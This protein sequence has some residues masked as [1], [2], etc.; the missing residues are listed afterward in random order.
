MYSSL[1]FLCTLLSALVTFLAT[2]L[3]SAAFSCFRP[4]LLL[5]LLPPTLHIRPTLLSTPTIRP[6]CGLP[7]SGWLQ[8][9]KSLLDAFRERDRREVFPAARLAD[10]KAMRRLPLLSD[11]T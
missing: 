10:V 5:P 1:C 6:P 9:L 8:E 4:L 7:S 11:L 3:L 2:H